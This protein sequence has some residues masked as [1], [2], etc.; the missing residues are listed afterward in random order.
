MS[1][2]ALLV[3]VFLWDS[4]WI[5]HDD[6]DGNSGTSKWSHKGIADKLRLGKS[7]VLKAI[8]GLLDAGLIQH[9]GYLPTGKG[10]SKARYRVTHPE[11]LDAQRYAISV[12]GPPSE[13]KQARPIK[14]DY[15]N[16]D[17]S[18]ELPAPPPPGDAKSWQRAID[19]IR[20]ACAAD[21]S[22]PGE[23]EIPQHILDGYRG[24]SAA[25]RAAQGLGEPEKG[26]RRHPEP[27]GWNKDIPK[28]ERAAL[29]R[30]NAARVARYRE[31]L[32]DT[33]MA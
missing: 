10:S 17:D 4:A 24:R 15:D 7:T 27:F 11:T 23:P 12:M 29:R 9:T 33:R 16:N 5:H 30:S 3:Y 26:T 6:E 32:N 20:A 18:L 22:H 8:N 13:R 1:P 31:K 25:V 14:P 2:T 28:E 21:G 19:K